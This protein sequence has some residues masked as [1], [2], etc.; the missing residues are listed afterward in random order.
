MKAAVTAV[1]TPGNA[2][3]RHFLT[4]AQYRARFEPTAAQ[5]AKVSAWLRSSGLR[6]AGVEPSR[7]YISAAGN[8]AVAEKAFGTTLNVYRH[9]AGCCVRR[10]PASSVPS[11]VVRVGDR[12]Y[13]ARNRSRQ[14][15]EV[16]R[17]TPAGHRHR[18]AVLA[19]IG[20]LVAKT[21][22]DYDPP[23]AEVQGQVP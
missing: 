15:A 19:L 10:R 8:V 18:A 3:Y 22:A 13:R 12:C 4:P 17:P 11:S 2:R 9:A 1:S 7:R 14:A 21:K 16:L 6:V 20:Q 23:A 5:V